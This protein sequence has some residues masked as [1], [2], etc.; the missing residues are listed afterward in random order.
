[1]SPSPAEPLLPILGIRLHAIWPPFISPNV[2]SKD[3]E[4]GKENCRPVQ[5]GNIRTQL[6]PRGK[7]LPSYV[8]NDIF[9][10]ATVRALSLPEF[11][12]PCIPQR[13]RSLNN[14]HTLLFYTQETMPLLPPTFHLHFL[15]TVA[16]FIHVYHIRMKQGNTFYAQI[17]LNLSWGSILINAS[18]IENTLNK[19]CM[20]T[21]WVSKRAS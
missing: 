5:K 13:R 2:H 11:S 1:M 21:T 10:L 6:P 12:M 17:F 3:S 8:W 7:H 14:W 4:W 15:G 20:L 9:I 18:W 16:K 19:K